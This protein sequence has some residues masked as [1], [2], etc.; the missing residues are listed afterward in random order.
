LGFFAHISSVI[1]FM[2]LPRERRRVIFYSEGPAYWTHLQGLLERFLDVADVPV[3]YFSSS[4]QDPGLDFSHPALKTFLI[5]EA[6]VRDWFFANVDTD[7]MVMSMP[8]LH[9]YQLK[10]SR[11]RVH[12]V[13]VQH[14]LVSQH[15][16]YKPGAFDHFDT[17][18]CAGPHHVTEIRALEKQRG[19]RAKNLV[20]HGYPR[21]DAIL[22]TRPTEDVASGVPGAPHVLIAPSWGPSGIIEKLGNAPIESLL[23]AG[24]RVTLR[25]HPQTIRKSRKDVDDIVRRHRQNPLFAFDDDASSTASLQASDLMISDWSGASLDYAFGLGKPVVFIDT[26]PKVNNPDYDELDIEPFESRIRTEV[27]EIVAEADLGS[28]GAAVHRQIGKATDSRLSAVADEHVFN[29]G[30]S[31]DIGVEALLNILAEAAS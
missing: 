2:Q 5:D 24:M 30:R 10:R 28:L 27:G 26:P 29:L 13:Y 8:D 21:L 16:A 7:L 9:Q 31:S 20:E 3:C 6:W 22:A 14:S 23:Q 1:S 19:T 4:P 25:P 18:F 15:M 17:I 11:H 12:Y